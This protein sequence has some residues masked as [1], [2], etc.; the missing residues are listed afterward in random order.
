[1][2]IQGDGDKFP[3]FTNNQKILFHNLHAF[4]CI[5]HTIL[6]RFTDCRYLSTCIVIHHPYQCIPLEIPMT[7][8]RVR[9]VK[10]VIP[11]PH[12]FCVSSLVW[13]RWWKIHSDPSASHASDSDE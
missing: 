10:K 1:M 13:N 5:A 3:N 12:R 6:H 7:T 11:R 8:T 2:G 9:F 4:M